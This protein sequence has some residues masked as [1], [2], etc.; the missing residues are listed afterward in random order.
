MNIYLYNETTNEKTEVISRILDG[1]KYWFSIEGNQAICPIRKRPENISIQYDLSAETIDLGI[2]IKELRESY[3][4]GIVELSTILGIDRKTMYNIESG[5]ILPR[6]D[7]L[8]RI[9]KF[10]GV[11]IEIG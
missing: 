6:V 1:E 3:G 10:L 2:T 5:K 9:A 8:F 11:K 7:T 4:Y